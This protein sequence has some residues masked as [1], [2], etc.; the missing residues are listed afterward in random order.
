MTVQSLFTMQTTDAGA[1]F[2]GKGQKNHKKMIFA[3]AMNFRAEGGGVPMAPGADAQDGKLSVCM[4]WGIPKWRTFLCLPLLVTANHLRIRGFEVT[5]CKEYD[6]K[7]KTPMVLHADGEY[8]GDVT[9][10]HFQC[11]PKKLHVMW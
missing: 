10:M 5:N 3:A 2:D 9:E 11:L 1:V 8:C 4:A 6:L 7:L